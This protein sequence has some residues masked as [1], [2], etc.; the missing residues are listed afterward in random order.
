MLAKS[1]KPSLLITTSFLSMLQPRE[2]GGVGPSRPQRL[3]LVC[4]GMT[5][6]WNWSRRGGICQLESGDVSPHSK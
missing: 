5:A 2:I 3:N 6:L 4:A 1:Q